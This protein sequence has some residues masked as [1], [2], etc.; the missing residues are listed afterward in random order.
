MKVLTGED[1]RQM[2]GSAKKE[3]NKEG[4]KFHIDRQQVRMELYL[5]SLFRII[6]SAK[7]LCFSLYIKLADLFNGLRSFCV[8][9]I[10]IVI[11]GKLNSLFETKL[12]SFFK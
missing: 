9:C 5:N 1:H 8:V 10:N 2:G 3:V 11:L 7:V 4:R 12:S 6:R